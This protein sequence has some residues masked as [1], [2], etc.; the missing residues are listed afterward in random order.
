[1]RLESGDTVFVPQIG[2]VVALVGRVNQPAIYELKTETRV[3]DLL[4][5]A[6]GVTP[7]GYLERVQLERFQANRDRIVEDVNL[8]DFYQRGVE[9][10]NPSLKN[11]DLVRVFPVD[12]RIYNAVSL[13]GL[14]KRPGRYALRPG[15]RA[16]DLVIPDELLPDAFLDR[17]EVVRLRTDLGTE[18]IPFSVRDAWAGKPEANIELRP[19][20]RV[21]IRSQVRPIEEVMVSGMVKRPGQYAVSRGER[22]SSVIERA[23]GLEPNAFP[24]G[25]VFTRRAVRV[26]EQQQLERFVR[27]QEQSLLAETSS[28][29]AG[30]SE[31]TSQNRGEL[32]A[33]QASVLTQRRELL[34]S[35]SSAVTLGRVAIRLDDA[36]LKDKTWD[37]E[38]EDGDT[39]HI[40]PQ[41]KSVLVLGAVRSSTALLYTGV[42]E[43]PDYYIGLAGGT[44]RE[45]DL[46]QMYVL[47][48]D[49]S[50][51]ASFPRVYNVEAGDT[52]I[53]P[54]S[55][56]PKYKPLPVLRDIATILAGFALPVAAVA[57]LIN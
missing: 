5:L 13:E 31:L 47:K 55:T 27:T 39:L 20:D 54:L 16:A 43:K 52:I 25:A 53:V 51:I 56:E 57:A 4:V 3:A 37:I 34:R 50:T 19:L 23:G 14:V 17:A 46:D 28:V 15:M 21:V 7:R 10:S 40:P 33:V 22:L 49:G 24:R 9:A 45:A 35:L 32:T 30:A 11:G 8:L 1:V 2:P 18:V 6:G 29:T 44:T 41:P 38:L 48:P 36:V 26:A 42:A 12:L